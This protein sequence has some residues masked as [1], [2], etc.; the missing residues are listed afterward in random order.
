MSEK[1]KAVLLHLWAPQLYIH[2][3]TQSQHMPM[4]RQTKT[5]SERVESILLQSCGVKDT[6]ARERPAPYTSLSKLPQLSSTQHWS[7]LMVA[8][9]QELGETK[10]LRKK[11]LL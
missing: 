1:G 5:K 11:D 8:R 4:P 2:K 10:G 7:F 6:R 3:P 9:T